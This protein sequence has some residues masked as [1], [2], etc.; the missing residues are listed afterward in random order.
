MSTLRNR[1]RAQILAEQKPMLDPTDYRTFLRDYI[2]TYSNRPYGVKNTGGRG[3]GQQDK[4]TYLPK[5]L[6]PVI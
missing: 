3:L 2:Q 5:S 4:S 6:L 1:M